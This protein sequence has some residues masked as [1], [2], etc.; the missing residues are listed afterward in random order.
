VGAA[1]RSGKQNIVEGS[2]A[3][4]TSKQTEIH[5]TNVAKASLGIPV[6]AVERRN[7]GHF[8]C[9]MNYAR[10][11][12]F[13]R[14]GPLR[15]RPTPASAFRRAR[16]GFG[17]QKA[18]ADLR[19]ILAAP[20][21]EDRD[22]ILHHAT[23]NLYPFMDE[24]ARDVQKARTLIDV[25]RAAR[26]AS[27]PG[28]DGA[29]EERMNRLD[30]VVRTGMRRAGAFQI[31]GSVGWVFDIPSA[32]PLALA[33]LKRDRRLEARG[34]IGYLDE[35][36]KARDDRYGRSSRRSG[37]ASRNSTVLSGLRL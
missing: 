2:L 12:V 34:A 36:F 13:A 7:G 33:A 30:H 19:R 1:A 26:E 14:P 10:K 25:A 18:I 4:A 15:C 9:S 28:R 11:S 6:L 35:H 27:G 20:D 23:W 16:Q 24:V 32:V 3:S 21:M 5:L 37:S 22:M 29:E 8:K 17:P 31:L